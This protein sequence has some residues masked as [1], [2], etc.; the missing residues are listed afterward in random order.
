MSGGPTTK[1]HRVGMTGRLSRTRSIVR[2]FMDEWF[3]IAPWM[4]PFGVP[5][6]S[7]FVRGVNGERGARDT[8]RPEP[9]IGYPYA[10]VGTAIDYRIRYY[11]QA[12]EPRALIGSWRGTRSVATSCFNRAMSAV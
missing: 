7:T 4:H 3:P 8:I 6:T 2:S 12:H 5:G 1:V 9:A 11:L 10:A